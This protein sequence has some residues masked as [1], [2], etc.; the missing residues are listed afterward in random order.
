MASE[1]MAM[2]LKNGASEESAIA[3]LESLFISHWDALEDPEYMTQ[4]YSTCDQIRNHGKLKLVAGDYFHFGRCLVRELREFDRLT[5]AHKGKDS[6]K[7]AYDK[8]MQNV[9]LKKQFLDVASA[10]EQKEKDIVVS[11]ATKIVLYNA[12]VT[13]SFHALIGHETKAFALELCGQK[14]AKS[15]RLAFRQNLQ[16]ITKKSSVASRRES[17]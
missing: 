11:E 7:W 6:V 13:K 5:I 2:I 14:A 15:Q 8:L 1:R 10:R 12:F 9:A 16:A 17:M 4:C 3:F